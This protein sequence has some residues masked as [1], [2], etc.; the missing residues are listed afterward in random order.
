MTEEGH[1]NGKFTIK[2]VQAEKLGKEVVEQHLHH[3]GA[4]LDAYMKKHWDESWEHYDV[5]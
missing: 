3:S 2:R 4:D 1:P 5:N